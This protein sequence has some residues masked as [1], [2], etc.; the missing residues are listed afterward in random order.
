[1][2]KT[3]LLL[4]M[5]FSVF[6]QTGKVA[7]DILKLQKEHVVFAHYA[8]FSINPNPASAEF[9]KTVDNATIATL[10]ASVTMQIMAENKEYIELDVPYNNT[11]ITISLYKTDVFAEGFELRTSDAPDA[12]KTIEKGHF[13]RGIIKGD[14]HSLVS[15]NFFKDQ[16]NGIISGH[17][18]RNIVVNKLNIKGNTT[19]YIVYSDA[20]LKLDNSFKCAVTEKDLKEIPAN[21]QNRNTLSNRCVTVYFEIDYDMY[22]ANGS[23]VV[24]TNVWMTSAFN[25]VQTLYNNDGISVAIKSIYVW[26]TPDPYLGDASWQYLQQ[27]H[28]QRPVF[29]GDVGQL[30]GIDSGLGGVA[31]VVDGLCSGNNYSYSDVYFD[32]NTVPV[33]SWTI[34]VI[35]HELGHL[36]GSPHTHGCYWNGDGTAID[37]CATTANPAY[38]EGNCPIGDV[39]LPEVG[40]TIMS[41]CHL[42]EGVGINFAN[43]FGPQ[44]A[45]RILQNV[46]AST[47]LSSNCINTCISQINN[48]NVT[49]VTYTSAELTWTDA[50]TTNTSWEVSV[51]T[52]PYQPVTWIPVGTNDYI[53]TGL[54]PNTSY[55]ICVRSACSAGL[56]AVSKCY[57]L[58]TAADFCAGQPFVD[59]GG[60]DHNYSDYEDWTRTVFPTDPNDKVKVTF[61]SIAIEDG[62][63]Y[64]YIFNGPNIES[65]MLAAITGFDVVGPFEST[66][67]SGALT[68][69]FDADTNT[70]L[71]GWDG[72][73]SCL[74]LGTSGNSLIDY[75]Y[76]PNPTTGILNIKSKN[77]IQSIAI[78]S[79][80]GKLLD[81][82][83]EK[84]FDAKVD[85][86][87]YATGTYVCSL[88]FEQTSTSFKVVRK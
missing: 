65:D 35:T 88:Q 11:V 13:Y 6:S 4:L 7:E 21:T 60:L 84:Q 59:S 14:V 38:A 15:F 42:L 80:D 27:F 74:D 32:F 81:Q 29:N 71:A 46:N 18:F 40:G 50:D 16:M 2:K 58:T 41:Y 55:D 26:T 36:L 9:T 25:N 47:C 20:K 54:S 66:D 12:K 19:D 85:L 24:Q 17:Q 86:S 68:F 3:I 45:A 39:P 83:N 52:Y 67:A 62:W 23:D 72:A 76:Y 34:E 63:D 64:L 69:Q 49:N 77:E 51:S 37:G 22:L 5:G 70:N 57:Y 1:M 48:L 31:A 78:Y 33:M 56:E 87:S 79:L 73:F 10:D 75:S 53:V 28:A 43:G 30:V 61:N 44:P 82:F 8:P